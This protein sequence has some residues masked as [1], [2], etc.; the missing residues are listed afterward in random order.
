MMIEIHPNIVLK[1]FI[2]KTDHI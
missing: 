2:N 1:N